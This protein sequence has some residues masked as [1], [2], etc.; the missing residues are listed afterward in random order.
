MRQL[1]VNRR[2]SSR[3]F[4]RLIAITTS[5]LMSLTGFFGPLATVSGLAQQPT[6][7]P[8]QATTN[9]PQ[10]QKPEKLEEEVVQLSTSLVQVPITVVDKNGRP[11]R[12]LKQESFKVF[13]D[14]VEQP[15]TTFSKHS[16]TYQLKNGQGGEATPDATQV[17]YK[18]LI[19]FDSYHLFREFS[20]ARD[21]ALKFVKEQ[22]GPEAMA[23]VTSTETAPTDPP[24]AFTAD[25]E[26]L[27]AAIQKIRQ[28]SHHIYD[29]GLE[30]D[31]YSAFMIDRG[32]TTVVDE[33]VAKFLRLNGNPE[34]PISQAEEPKK[35]LYEGEGHKATFVQ[36]T[37]QG[38]P[39][40]G[41]GGTGGGS[42]G[43]GSTGG[44][45]TGGGPA[46]GGNSTG[47][48]GTGGN[49]GGTNSGRG[50]ASGMNDPFSSMNSSSSAGRS[51]A[52][53]QVKSI[54]S[55]IV[56]E[57]T[58]NTMRELDS[59]RQ[60]M[61]SFSKVEGRKAMVLLSEG[62]YLDLG[63]RSA[64]PIN[65]RIQAIVDLA[66]RTNT[67]IYTLD[68]RGLMALS[69]SSDI[70]GRRQSNS[71]SR[72]NASI[73]ESQ[74]GLSLLAT[75]TGGTGFSNNN[76][77]SAGFQG[78]VRDNSYYYIVGYAPN[79]APDGKFRK[80][81]VK[82]DGQDYKA[83]AR[84][85]YFALLPGQQVKIQEIVNLTDKQ[86]K[87]YLKFSQAGT[88]A[89][90]AKKF[91]ES[92]DNYQKALGYVP[93]D[94]Q[95]HYFLGFDYANKKDLD[96]AL[97]YWKKADE[98]AYGQIL[99]AKVKIVQVL[100][101]RDD[102]AGA[103]PYLESLATAKPN[104][105]PTQYQYALV[106]E[107]TNDFA[108]ALRYMQAAQSVATQQTNPTD[109]EILV[110]LGRVSL[111]AGKTEGFNYLRE[112]LK[113]NGINSASVKQFLEANHEKP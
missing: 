74:N 82:V 77:V 42:T 92:I 85:G 60:I 64:F 105:F 34:P 47:G 11:V 52:V 101:S 49:T 69:P 68:V 90:K 98:Y 75:G 112:Y 57:A 16:G 28:R 40:G 71:V 2:L 44:G 108:G 100:L 37:F 79:K 113:K 14:G 50:G 84:E 5:L 95:V 59:L 99:D 103:K 32:D 61:Q 19:V 7:D 66:S 97:D 109:V 10:A 20:R 62:F 63:N 94:A 58:L 88:E 1:R 3:V 96:K 55:Q 54:A 6:Q 67:T 21:A 24:A 9:P 41:G 73:N 111:R 104:D 87:E 27:T 15:I 4:A 51:S 48:F 31:E 26:Q 13:E 25:S 36:A 53:A 91:D 46:G 78:V 93:R 38:K 107:K 80:I 81:T 72:S 65:E 29:G 33:F 22:K 102:N 23:A 76:D 89:L 39:P 56:S 86:Q 30:M 8:K 70:S 17:P 18:F 110:D 106:L 43:G 12:A 83:R 35:S 45:P